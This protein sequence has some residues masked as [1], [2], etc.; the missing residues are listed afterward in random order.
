MS[1]SSRTRSRT[2]SLSN[3]SSMSGQMAGQ[4][5]DEDLQ[6]LAQQY[7]SQNQS[8]LQDEVK[9]AQWR[10]FEGD[11]ARQYHVPA[12]VSA[13]LLSPL[14][15]QMKA[16]L[17]IPE[18]RS[19]SRSGSP[20][21]TY[22]NKHN[23]WIDLLREE[24][25]K[26]KEVFPDINAVEAAK[27]LHLFYTPQRG[28]GQPSSFDYQAFDEA[29]QAARKGQ[30]QLSQ[31]VQQGANSMRNQTT[32]TQRTAMTSGQMDGGYNTRSRSSNS[33]RAQSPLSPT[34]SARY[35]SATNNYTGSNTASNRYG[36][37]SASSSANGGYS[38]RRLSGGYS[39]PS[40]SYGGRSYGGSYN[41]F[42]Y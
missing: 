26:L 40:A 37:S 19:R 11:F 7:V 15:D 36:S 21:G 4:M 9:N 2:G 35:S 31:A 20:N 25:P 6:G 1:A 22:G 30:G 32:G 28:A 17:G 3:T 18:R 23:P 27:A 33:G 8:Q 10:Q 5:S 12:N 41:R 39:S 16:D 13:H 14:Y 34:S 24:I 29:L 38:A 42:G